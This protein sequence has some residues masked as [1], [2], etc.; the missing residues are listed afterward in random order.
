MFQS[1]DT[2]K[3]VIANWGRNNCGNEKKR[4]VPSCMVFNEEIPQE[5]QQ[6]G[7]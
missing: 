4:K 6:P 1:I 5:E 2:H 3:F 7:P